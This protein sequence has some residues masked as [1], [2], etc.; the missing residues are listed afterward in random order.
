MLF[1]AIYDLWPSANFSLSWDTGTCI[2]NHIF[3]YG[4]IIALH[5]S[6]LES[7]SITTDCSCDEVEYYPKGGLYGLKSLKRLCWR[8]PNFRYIDDLT[9][10]IYANAGSLQHLEVDLVSW[11]RVGSCM[12]LNPFKD[13]PGGLA[14][15]L[16]FWRVPEGKIANPTHPVLQTLCLT[17]VGLSKEAV[18][19]FD[20]GVLRTLK[21]R[22]CDKW[23][24]LLEEAVRLCLPIGLKTLEIHTRYNRLYHIESYEGEEVW[25]GGEVLLKFLAAF[26]GLEELSVGL[27]GTPVFDKILPGLLGHRATLKRFVHD[28]RTVSGQWALERVPSADSSLDDDEFA[29]L[30]DQFQLEAMGLSLNPAQLVSVLITD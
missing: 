22:N 27:E 1:I 28:L 10:M 26:S 3:G 5:Q 9:D 13:G 7:L 12:R 11:E 29:R 23:D 2:T 14:D 20:F 18:G 30:L 19:V 17:E 6:Q 8:A 24:M 15:S 16:R 4:G 21:L 25:N